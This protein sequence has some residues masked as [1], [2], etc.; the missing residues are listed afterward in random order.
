MSQALIGF[1]AGLRNADKNA[2]NVSVV[3]SLTNTVKVATAVSVGAG[4]TVN[5]TTAGQILDARNF[6]RFSVASKA[7]S[8]HSHT[9]SS[10][11]YSDLI[12]NDS[13]GLISAAGTSVSRNINNGVL[14][15]DYVGASITNSDTVSHTYDVWLRLMQ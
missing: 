2:L 9:L 1:I 8:S 14:V 3:G 5:L 12:G 7:N 13:I 4:A 6:S 11:G 10:N 15:M